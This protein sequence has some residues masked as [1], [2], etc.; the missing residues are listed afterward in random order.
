MDSRVIIDR[1]YELANKG[2]WTTWLT[3]FDD[4]V[5]GDEQIAGHFEGIDV[6]RGAGD[7][8]QKGYKPF[9]MQ[10]L[11]VVVDG[12]QACVIWRCDSRNANEVPIAYPGDPNRPVI[13]ANYFR[14]ANGKI[15]YMRTVHDVIPFQPF[16]QQSRPFQSS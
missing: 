6:L 3:L 16:V 12:D 8:I 5:I 10:P 11:Q 13:G 7:A 1:Y 4:N 14:F 2:D 15:V 9:H